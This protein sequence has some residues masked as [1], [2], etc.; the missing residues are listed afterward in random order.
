[1]LK[2][3]YYLSLTPEVNWLVHRP[4]RGKYTNVCTNINKYWGFIQILKICIN[5]ENFNTKTEKGTKT[6]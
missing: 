2:I 1:M 6:E 3:W 5:I 4:E